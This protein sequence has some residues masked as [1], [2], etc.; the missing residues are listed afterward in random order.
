[1][2]NVLLL[3]GYKTTFLTF[4]LFTLFGAQSVIGQYCTPTFIM[5]CTDDD[6]IDNFST[7][8]GITNI[9]NN[10]SGCSAGSYQYVT[11]QSVSQAPG[12]TVTLSM[13][14]GPV[15]AEGFKVWID[16]DNNNSFAD[17]GEL[18]YTSPGYD[19][20]VFTT[21]VTVP[22]GATPGTKRMRVLC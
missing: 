21:T 3:K 13:Q 20:I 6:L 7:S 8:G 12:Q 11:G 22:V 19:F 16:W 9:S 4:I 2:K 10:G 18:V 17:A 15:F 1:M 14:C 5:G